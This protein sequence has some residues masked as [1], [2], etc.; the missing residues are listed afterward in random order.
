[1]KSNIVHYQV[2]DPVVQQS[3][4]QIY[5]W[6]VPIID[7]KD[8]KTKMYKYNIKN[9]SQISINGKWFAWETCVGDACATMC[10][11]AGYLKGLLMH[12]IVC[13]DINHKHKSCWRSVGSGGGARIMKYGL[14][15]LDCR[16]RVKHRMKAIVHL[17]LS[18]LVSSKL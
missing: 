18:V 9:I 3:A 13:H 4:C 10:T 11:Y 2:H 17:D 5:R 12:V 7:D 14:M 15:F 1:M 6:T 16:K 8:H